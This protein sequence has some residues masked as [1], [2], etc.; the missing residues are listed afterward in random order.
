MLPRL[1][2]FGLDNSSAKLEACLLLIQDLCP[3]QAMLETCE[4]RRTLASRK[5]SSHVAASAT[6]AAVPTSGQ[7]APLSHLDAVDVVHGGL[8]GRDVIRIANAVDAVEGKVYAV[9]RPYQE[10]QNR[11]ARRLLLRPRE[12]L[13]FIR[14]SA[15]TLASQTV[16]APQQPVVGNFP[17]ECPDVHKIISTEREQHM[18]TEILQRAVAGTDV[19][20]ICKTERLAGL[21]QI[22]DNSTVPLPDG[23]SKHKTTRLWPFLL[24]FVYLM[25]PV[26]GFIFAA[27]QTSRWL[28]DVF[29]NWRRPQLS[30][31]EAKGSFDHKED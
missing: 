28:T 13:T 7:G 19:L 1:H 29:R 15:Q 30:Q 20:V 31:A 9:D 11:V 2:F 12:L 5:R 16:H 25:L 14:H 3:K 23:S 10:T 6:G 22:L 24:V 27:W 4:Q 18:A 21:K 26:Y 8:C 17:E